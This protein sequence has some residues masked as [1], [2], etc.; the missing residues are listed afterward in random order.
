MTTIESN[1]FDGI[2]LLS[3]VSLIEN[4]AAIGGRSSSSRSFSENTF[5]NSTLYVP[6]GT[7]EKYKATE[8]WKDFVFIEEGVPASVANVYINDVQIQSEGGIIHVQGCNDG[9]QVC[10]YSINGSEVGSAVFQNGKAVVNTTLK[11]G[12]VAILKVG[13]KSFKFVMK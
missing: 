10:I 8:G 6:A 7:I 9:E 12:S 4:P 13:Q 3:V 11:P 5:Y 2:N 1:A